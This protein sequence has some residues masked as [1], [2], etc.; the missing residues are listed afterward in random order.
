MKH[1]ILYARANLYLW[2]IIRNLANKKKPGNL[3]RWKKMKMFAHARECDALEIEN[4]QLMMSGQ[5]LVNLVL[6]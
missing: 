1:S 6:V 4:E 3:A 2:I 5:E